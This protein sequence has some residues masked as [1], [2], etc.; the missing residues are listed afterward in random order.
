MVEI[1][2][3]SDHPRGSIIQLLSSDYPTNPTSHVCLLEIHGGSDYP[4]ITTEIWFEIV[5]SP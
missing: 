3:G 1:H 2:G 4:V 5:S